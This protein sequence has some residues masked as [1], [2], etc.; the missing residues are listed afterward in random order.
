[1]TTISSTEVAKRFGEYAQQAQ[2]EPVEVTSY[3]R[4]YVTI[5][6]A[7]EYERLRRLDRQAYAASELPSDI[8]AAIAKSEPSSDSERF[9]DEIE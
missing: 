4:P 1:M 6:S 8:A 9:D 7:R 2:H 3:N 5:L